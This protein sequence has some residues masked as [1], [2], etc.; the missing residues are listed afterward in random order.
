[1]RATI[2][3]NDKETFELVDD[4]DGAVVRVKSVWEAMHFVGIAYYLARLQRQNELPEE[5]KEVHEQIVEDQP[6]YVAIGP[7]RFRLN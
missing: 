5:A 2:Y 6:F 3:S 4:G 1:M 7:F